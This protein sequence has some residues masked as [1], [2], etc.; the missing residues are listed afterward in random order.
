MPVAR[1]RTALRALLQRLRPPAARE[2]GFAARLLTAVVFVAALWAPL[3]LRYLGKGAAYPWD[4]KGPL[5][6]WP[7]TTA[8]GEVREYAKTVDASFTD[9]FPY[10]ERMIAWQNRLLAE[11]LGSSGVGHVVVGRDRWLYADIDHSFEQFRHARPRSDDHLPAWKEF[12]VG[13]RDWL[14]PRGCRLLVVVCPNKETIYPEYVPERLRPRGDAPH[15][16]DVWV[17][18]VT[19]AGVECLD[20]RGT[21]ADAKTRGQVYLRLD[22]HWNQAAAVTAYRTIATRLARDFPAIRPIPAEEFRPIPHTNPGRDLAWNLRIHWPEHDVWLHPV[23]PLRARVV[24][25]WGDDPDLYRR[26]EVADPSLPRAVVAHDSFFWTLDWLLREH[27]SRSAWRTWQ[28]DPVPSV[29]ESVRPQVY[30]HELVERA[31]VNRAPTLSLLHAAEF[32]RCDRVV[33]RGGTGEI[34][35]IERE[36]GRRA[37]VAVRAESEKG[38]HAGDYLELVERTAGGRRWLRPLRPG[39]HL[40]YFA[41]P[42][43]FAGPADVRATRGGS[44]KSVEVRTGSAR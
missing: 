23:P 8:G 36:P 41:L 1:P 18:R 16:T 27:F 40:D 6:D 39:E 43:D 22:S 26:V 35:V 13:L 28:V 10:R 12:L 44:V 4:V 17:G 31:L 32:D 33:W 38:A 15:P 7:R 29:I 20:L 14:E 30:V 21:M 42:A 3:T 24:R 2:P 9:H 19:A 34:P 5:E 11:E 25:D 37:V